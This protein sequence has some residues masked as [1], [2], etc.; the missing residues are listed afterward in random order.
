MGTVGNFIKGQK[1]VLVRDTD[2]TLVNGE[3]IRWVAGTQ[4]EIVHID[5]QGSYANFPYKDREVTL[6]QRDDAPTPI[7]WTE[8][9]VECD[10]R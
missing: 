1:V 2:H 3:T 8:R 10:T 6:Y 4:G 9:N 7:Y 5:L